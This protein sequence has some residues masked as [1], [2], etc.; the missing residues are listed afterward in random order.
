MELMRFSRA[1]LLQFARFEWPVLV[2]VCVSLLLFVTNCTPGTYLIGWDNTVPEF[3]L[4]LNFQRILHGVWQD[5]RGLGTL[6][7]MA[8]SANIV[9]W[10]MLRFSLLSYHKVSYAMSFSS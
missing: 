5:Y 7:G 4:E 10:F 8:H 1:R 9:H 3:N 2:L 6:D